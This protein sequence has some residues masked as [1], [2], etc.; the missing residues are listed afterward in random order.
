[1]MVTVELTLYKTN[2][3]SV[4]ADLTELVIGL[5]M[6]TKTICTD[7]RVS[8]IIIRKATE[9]QERGSRQVSAVSPDKA[10]N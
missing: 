7:L 4:N 5:L 10:R 3:A 1:M 2:G 9:V 8:A 6:V